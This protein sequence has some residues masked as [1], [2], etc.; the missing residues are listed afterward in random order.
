MSEKLLPFTMVALSLGAAA[1][2]A[3][4]KDWRR[5]AYW[6]FAAGLTTTVTVL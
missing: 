2:Y 6:M 3:L 1:V 4:A 5:A